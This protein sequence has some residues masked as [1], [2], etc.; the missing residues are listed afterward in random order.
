M[1][2]IGLGRA[3]GQREIDFGGT[4]EC[5]VMVGH[6]RM[7]GVDPRSV[8][9]AGGLFVNDFKIELAALVFLPSGADGVFESDD[10]D[11]GGD[12]S[13]ASGADFDGGGPG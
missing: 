5:A 13:V 7:G 11:I 12:G 9:G 10:D 3:D 2:A 8:W 1:I 6:D 4:A